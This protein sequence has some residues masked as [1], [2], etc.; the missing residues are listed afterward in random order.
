MNLHFP[1][2]AEVPGLSDFGSREGSVFYSQRLSGKEY[3]G[4]TY[5]V[6]SNSWPIPSVHRARLHR[7]DTVLWRL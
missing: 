5:R 2:P 1:N 3:V 6:F 4:A 7:P